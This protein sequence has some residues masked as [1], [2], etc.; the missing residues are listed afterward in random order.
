MPLGMSTK[1]LS[2]SN[3]AKELTD[4]IASMF[5]FLAEKIVISCI[6]V[7]LNME[8]YYSMM[9]ANLSINRD[10][11]KAIIMIIVIPVFSI[12]AHPYCM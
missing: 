2:S 6:F 7:V 10:T 12:I 11:S 8:H 9:F 4:A 1:L 3:R 5:C